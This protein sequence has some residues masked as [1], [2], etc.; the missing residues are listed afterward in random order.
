[1]SDGSEMK[2]NQPIRVLWLTALEAHEIN[3]VG[4]LT[5]VLAFVEIWDLSH[6]WYKNIFGAKMYFAKS[7][8][9]A[10]G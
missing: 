9:S 5:L 8:T 6:P 10:V 2:N 7:A 3:F 4:K 1:M